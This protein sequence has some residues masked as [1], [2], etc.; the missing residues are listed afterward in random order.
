MDSLISCVRGFYVKNEMW[1][2]KC[3]NYEILNF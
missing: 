3:K 2:K 1:N